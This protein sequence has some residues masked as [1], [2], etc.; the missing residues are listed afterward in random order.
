MFVAKIFKDHGNTEIIGLTDQKNFKRNIFCLTIFVSIDA[1]RSPRESAR[2]VLLRHFQQFVDD[3]GVVSHLKGFLEV[4]GGRGLLILCQLYLTAKDVEVGCGRALGEDAAD[5]RHG[6]C[7]LSHHKIEVGPC[8][9]EAPLAGHL[10]DEVVEDALALKVVAP[11]FLEDGVAEPP[12][13]GTFVHLDDL[14]EIRLGGGEGAPRY[15]FFRLIIS[16]H[17]AKQAIFAPDISAYRFN[18]SSP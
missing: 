6:A 8:L 16:G 5:V 9:V 15:A 11:Y 10:A 7:V 4:G 12:F 2:F 18:H 13:D 14:I 1:G 3:L 17:A